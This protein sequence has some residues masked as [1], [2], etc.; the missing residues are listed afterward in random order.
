VEELLESGKVL[1]IDGVKYI[2]S[3]E[4]LLGSFGIVET[5]KAIKSIQFRTDV[6]IVDIDYINKAAQE[7][8][9]YLS[10]KGIG[11]E[12]TSKEDEKNARYMVV[13]I[14]YACKFTGN[15]LCASFMKGGFTWEGIFVGTLD[16][17]IK[18]VMNNYQ[19]RFGGIT[20]EDSNTIEQYKGNFKIKGFGLKEVLDN[21]KKEVVTDIS[22]AMSD[23]MMNKLNSF[24]ET[25]TA[26]NNEETGK[27]GIDKVANNIQEDTIDANTLDEECT[28]P[29]FFEKRRTIYDEI[30]DRLLIKENWKAS[31]KNRLSFYLKSL[32]EKIKYEQ[33]KTESLVGN[34][35]VLSNDRTKCMFNT[36]LIDI[37]NNDIYLVDLDNKEDDFYRKEV[38]MT[39][40]KATL[41][42]YGFNK[43][44]IMNMPKP[45]RF[46]ENKS[47]LVFSGSIAEFDLEDNHRLNHIIQERR[48]R[49]PEQYQEMSCD[50]LCEKV[51]SAV[52]KAVRLSERDYKYI[53][54]MYN[55]KMNKIQYLIPLHLSASIEESPELVIVVGENNG[56][57]CVYTIL[58]T[59]DAYDNARLLCRP[60]SAWLKVS[61]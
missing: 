28:L 11:I 32:A 43:E 6:S 8:L 59:D 20:D 9:L 15:P 23:E 18:R 2:G 26:E 49:F 37:Y 40:S 48:S 53:V 31:S 19:E 16:N 61:K 30:Y 36:G 14:G 52:S 57:Y 50:V 21:N 56:F 45:A 60:D 46:Y 22:S 12:G 5:E 42:N 24:K 58:T 17:L 54:P 4:S 41:I 7:G 33:T 38:V 35:Y 39:G 27:S 34:G 13:P 51:K 1:E 10:D 44:D 3:K 25:L 47:D 29:K 55:L